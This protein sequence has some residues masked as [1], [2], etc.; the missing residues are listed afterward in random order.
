M[1]T[2]RTFLRQAIAAAL[3]LVPV[4]ALCFITVGDLRYSFQVTSYSE[5]YVCDLANTSATDI[6]IPSTVQYDGRTS[7]VTG[8]ESWAFDGDSDLTSVFIPDSVTTIGWYAFRDC[9]GLTNVVIGNSVTSIGH[10]A[11]Y[12][13]SSLTNVSIPDSVTGIGNYTFS[14][15]S[16]LTSVTI[17]DS[18]TDIEFR[19][20][21]GCS[22]LTSVTIPD[23]VTSIGYGAFSS[24]SGLTNV[25][26]G[27]SVTNIGYLAFLSCSGLTSVTIPQYVCEG[28]LSEVFPD[29]RQ[30]IENIVIGKA[31]THIIGYEAFSGCSCLTNVIIPDSVTSIG[32]SAFRECSGLKTLS[33]PGAWE[34]TDMLAN[35]SVPW[36]C[37]VVYRSPVAFPPARDEA[38]VATV[39]AGAAD[40]RLAERI[41]SVT[42]YDDF[43]AWMDGNG[44]DYQTVKD[45]LHAWPSYLLGA[46]TLLA[47]EPEIRLGGI[48]VGEGGAMSVGVTVKDGGEPVAVDA[49]KLAALFSGTGDLSGWGGGAE[50][51]LA[52]TPK[53]AEGDTLLFEVVPGGTPEKAFLRIAE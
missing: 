32:G 26:I 39:L 11:F 1:P 21:S 23:S 29:A 40:A 5:V 47:N 27:N 51:E 50:L 33:V 7:R 31:V 10:H 3:T 30:N 42:E 34:G 18:V 37:E 14:G 36:W 19:A 38:E 16:S 15:C 2:F 48:A 43:R 6:T 49:G 17:P 35:A 41:G 46:A 4:S 28:R 52:V 44:L 9:R 45:S 53:G 25:V 24:C 20:F 13:C 12:G 8:I 22:G